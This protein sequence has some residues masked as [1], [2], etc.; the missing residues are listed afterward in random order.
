MTE[1]SPQPAWL[2]LSLSTLTFGTL[3]GTRGTC[4]AVLNRGKL[5][6]VWVLG[7]FPFSL[8]SFL[9]SLP[10]MSKWTRNCG[11]L[12]VWQ[13]IGERVYIERRLNYLV[14]VL[15]WG[16]WFSGRRRIHSSRSLP[17]PSTGSIQHHPLS[18]SYLKSH[19][20]A[21]HLILSAILTTVPWS[22][23]SSTAPAH[24][25][26][27][28]AS[29]FTASRKV[30]LS[31]FFFFVHSHNTYFPPWVSL[32]LFLTH[33]FG[34]F[35]LPLNQALNQCLCFSYPLTCDRLAGCPL[36]QVVCFPQIPILRKNWEHN[37]YFRACHK[38][39]GQFSELLLAKTFCLA[40]LHVCS[41]ERLL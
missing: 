36:N 5:W 14:L 15:V 25:P 28:S 13:D 26:V 24:H 34:I 9:P 10:Q 4:K 30:N 32:F 27:R 2:C 31:P 38:C 29:L 6:W 17:S 20:P 11:F 12:L 41:S 1:P 3:P 40:A 33:H 8:E 16:G 22:E 19:P 39:W 21:P 18:H 37:H 7:F 23:G 35:Q